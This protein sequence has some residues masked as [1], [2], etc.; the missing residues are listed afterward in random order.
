[1][2]I[3]TA[4]QGRTQLLTSEECFARRPLDRTRKQIRLIKL[5]QTVSNGIIECSIKTYDLD[6]RPKYRALSYMWGSDWPARTILVD[7]KHLSIRNNLYRFLC[8]C[9]QTDSYKRYRHWSFY[10]PDERQGLLWIDQICIDQSNVLERNHQVSL[11]VKICGR[12]ELVIVARR[13]A[14]FPNPECLPLILCNPYFTG[15]WIVQEVILAQ[16][17]RVLIDGGHW[18]LWSDMHGALAYLSKDGMEQLKSAGSIAASLL[19]HK[20]LIYDLSWLIISFHSCRCVEPRD[21]VF[22]L[23]GLFPRRLGGDRL[24]VDYQRSVY[25]I[26]LEVAVDVH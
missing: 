5:G 8:T 9:L 1:M 25:D 3:A 6:A 16:Y 22:G 23:L 2:S 15:L 11:M 21:K 26:F 20:S 4:R 19:R 24:H 13:F 7:G 17:I 18:L 12:A 10:D 14:H